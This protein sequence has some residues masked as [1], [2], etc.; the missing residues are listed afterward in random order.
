MGGM[1]L[2]ALVH[3][4]FYVAVLSGAARGNLF[5]TPESKWAALLW[6]LCWFNLAACYVSAIVLAAVAA[7]RRGHGRFAWTAVFLPVYWLAISVAAYRA[8]IDLVRRPHYWAKTQHLGLFMP[9]EAIHPR[10]SEKPV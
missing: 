2:A 3:P 5:V 9:D 6:W 8:L 7:R 4:L 1:V 10:K